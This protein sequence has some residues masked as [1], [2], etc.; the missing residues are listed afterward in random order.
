MGNTNGIQLQRQLALWIGSLERGSQT[1][2][3]QRTSDGVKQQ[4]TAQSRLGGALDGL[5]EWLDSIRWPAAMGLEQYAWEPPRVAVMKGKEREARLKSLG[6][7][8]NPVQVFP[9]L[10]AIKQIHSAV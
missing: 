4:G 6:N 9:I 1:G 7:A 5:S 3:H 8:V 10:W 2:Q